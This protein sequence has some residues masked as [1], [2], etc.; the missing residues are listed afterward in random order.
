MEKKV[1]YAKNLSTKEKPYDVIYVDVG[2]RKINLTFDRNVIA[3]I[4][5]LSVLDLL[6]LPVGTVIVLGVLNHDFTN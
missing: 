3:E 5:G 6:S 4:L 2:Y 1:I